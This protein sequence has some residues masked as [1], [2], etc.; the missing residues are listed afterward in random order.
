M[1]TGSPLTIVLLNGSFLLVGLV[2][3]WLVVRSTSEA[4][5]RTDGVTDWYEQT[6]VLAGKVATA[7]EAGRGT[8]EVGKQL[9][10]LSSKLKRHAR[11]APSAV[12]RT[13]LQQ[14][15]DLAMDCQKLGF[16]HTRT[17]GIEQGVFVE[18][19]LASVRERAVSLEAAASSRSSASVG[20]THG[21]GR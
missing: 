4:N 2:V 15:F 10:P 14:V 12:D 6:C 19:R 18:D 21:C 17:T 7:A 3:V 1:V 9:V 16:E 13:V 8:G 5:H 20:R 11:E